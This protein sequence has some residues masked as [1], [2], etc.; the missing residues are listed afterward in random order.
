VRLVTVYFD[1][2]ILDE[3]NRDFRLADR[4]AIKLEQRFAATHC[5]EIRILH[6]E[7]AVIGEQVRDRLAFAVRDV[8]AIAGGQLLN[9]VA[10]LQLLNP[11]ID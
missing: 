9:L 1:D 3:R 2:V 10:I 7:H 4:R 5:L 6:V 8:P 11:L